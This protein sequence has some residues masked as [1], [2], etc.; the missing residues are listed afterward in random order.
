MFSN[1]GNK[2]K[3]LAVVMCII[4]MS[5]SVISGLVMIGTDDDLILPGI[6]IMLLGCLFS[7]LS[8]FFMYGFGELVDTNQRLADALA[9]NNNN[10]YNPNNYV[11]Q[12]AP[13]YA[14][15][16]TYSAPVDNNNAYYPNNNQ[17]F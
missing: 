4:S 7:W 2:I 10:Q 1:I 6:F 12:P 14:P 17:Q 9:N 5:F 3:T 13:N 16:Y 15:N 8:S 11:Q